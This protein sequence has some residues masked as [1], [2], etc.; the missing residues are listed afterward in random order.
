MKKIRFFRVLW[1]VMIIWLLVYTIAALSI[2]SVDAG[3]AAFAFFI[4]A[5]GSGIGLSLI[6][7]V[8]G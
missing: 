2:Y 1:V 8:T 3:E 6:Y 5:V 4:G 7:I